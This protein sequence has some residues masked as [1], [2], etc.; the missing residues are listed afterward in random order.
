M[1]ES[2]YM[3]YNKQVAD[4]IYKKRKKS[5]HDTYMK[6]IAKKGNRLI[7]F[8]F[9]FAFLFF[10]IL[11]NIYSTLNGSAPLICSY[12]SKRSIVNQK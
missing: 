8:V 6:I 7:H 1:M 3:I 5:F 11:I 12:G 4:N 2:I 9:I 10:Y